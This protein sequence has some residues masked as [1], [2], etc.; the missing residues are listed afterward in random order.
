MKRRYVDVTHGQLHFRELGDGPPLV[1]LHKTPSSS[2]QYE[3]AMP[4]LASHFRTIALDTPGFGMSDPPAT[5]PSMADY[6]RIVVEFLDALEL[7]SVDLVGHHTGASIA[8]ETAVARPERVRRLALAGVLA[9]NDE[10]VRAEWRTYLD[11]HKFELDNTGAFLET[12]PKP[13]LSRDHEFSP[14]DPERYWLELVA[15]LQAGPRFWW[16]YNA[17]VEHRA[18]DLL[19]TLTRPT[20]VLNQLEGRVYESTKHVAE[21]VPEATYVELP[22]SSEGVMDDPAAFSTALLEF[23]R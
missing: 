10:T 3:R 2:I 5:Q 7:D 12:Y 1:L 4:L 11:S 15:Y 21:A 19:P 18:F 17:V 13:M 14:Q 23:L 20:L 9:F 6:G 16:S 8:I 22:G